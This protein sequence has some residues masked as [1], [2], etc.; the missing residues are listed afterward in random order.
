MLDTVEDETMKLVASACRLLTL[1]LSHSPT[2]SLSLSHSL[3]HS[4]TLSLT[5]HEVGGVDGS[6]VAL[7]VRERKVEVDLQS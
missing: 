3:S 1:S 5:H 7:E 4:P 2:L 6:V